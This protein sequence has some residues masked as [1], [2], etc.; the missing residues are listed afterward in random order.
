MENFFV[1][2]LGKLEV[3]FGAGWIASLDKFEGDYRT[4]SLSWMSGGRKMTL[5]GDPSLGR[6]QASGKT[7]LNAL[8]N[9][10]EGFLVTPLFCSESIEE[11]PPISAVGFNRAI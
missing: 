3:V 4:L 8:R 7:A 9:D 1:M 6:S 10:E 5:Q 2:E 11:H